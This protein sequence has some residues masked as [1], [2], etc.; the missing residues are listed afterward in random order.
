MYNA[1]SRLSARPVCCIP[2]RAALAADAP[3]AV[4]SARALAVAAV[5]AVGGALLLLL[6][7][8][9]HAAAAAAVPLQLRRRPLLRLRRLPRQQ[10]GRQL[11]PQQLRR[12]RQHVPRRGLDAARALALQ[13]GSRERHAPLNAR[14]MAQQRKSISRAGQAARIQLVELGGGGRLVG[15][16]PAEGH[17]AGRRRRGGGLLRPLH[18]ALLLRWTAAGAAGAAA[19]TVWRARRFVGRRRGERE[20]IQQRGLD[21]RRHAAEPPARRP[22][23]LRQLLPRDRVAQLGDGPDDSRELPV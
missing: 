18:L 23:Q 10:R 5:A 19:A 2:P 12:L 14:Q 17:G 20:A 15:L 3:R 21:P 9:L 1:S 16:E 7:L 22:E 4:P 11:P 8:L 13:R 6:L